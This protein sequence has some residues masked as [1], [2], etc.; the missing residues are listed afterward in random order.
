MKMKFREERGIGYCGMACVLCCY[1]GYDNCRGCAADYNKKADDS[2]VIQ[3]A[4][5]KGVDG[6]FDCHDYPCGNENNDCFVKQC[7]RQK[8]IDGC[9]ACQEFL[10]NKNWPLLKNKRNRAFLRFMRDFG[11][12][13]LIDRLRINNENGII[14][15]KPGAQV[16][17]KVCGDYDVP[18]TENEIYQ[19]LRYGREKSAE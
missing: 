2:V 13:T 19:L 5:E 10:C 11:K 12:N 8:Q 15:Q 16:N 7:V 1:E 6:C 3:C 14:F 9:F 17:E 18:E 4:G